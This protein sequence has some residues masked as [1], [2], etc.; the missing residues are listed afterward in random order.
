MLVMT[1]LSGTLACKNGVRRV[2]EEETGMGYKTG[3]G[4]LLE[5]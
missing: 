3:G 2:R 1:S 5:Q 4:S